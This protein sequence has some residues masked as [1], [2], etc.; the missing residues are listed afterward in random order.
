MCKNITV[1]KIQEI[2]IGLQFKEPQ[3]EIL[4]SKMVHFIHQFWVET[5]MEDVFW[6]V[7]NFYKKQ[8]RYNC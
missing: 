1:L 2:L 8:P 4:I 7:T 5:I 3:L 6:K